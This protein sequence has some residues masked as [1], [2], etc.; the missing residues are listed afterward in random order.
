MPFAN[1]AE[2]RRSGQFAT[3]ASERSMSSPTS[4]IPCRYSVYK[5][6]VVMRRLRG[7]CRSL[8]TDSVSKV[9]SA[10]VLYRFRHKLPPRLTVQTTG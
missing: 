6:A 8:E 3:V 4:A 2:S 9:P 5:S 10:L 1:F 7:S